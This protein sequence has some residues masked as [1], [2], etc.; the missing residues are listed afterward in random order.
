MLCPWH[1][2]ASYP[3]VNNPDSA[4]FINKIVDEHNHDLS[5]EAVK[6]REDKKFNDEIVRDIQ[7]MTDHYLYATIKKFR[8][9]VKSLSND[10]AQM[11][12]WLDKQK[13]QDSRWIIARGWDDDNTL[14]HLLWMTPEQVES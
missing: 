5:V 4:I 9:T 13:E 2:N 7:F 8:L 12:D 3:K 10:A 14:T 1:V 6:F 11:S